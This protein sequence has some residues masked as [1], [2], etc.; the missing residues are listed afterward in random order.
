M[1]KK[2]QKFAIHD[3]FGTKSPCGG[4]YLFMMIIRKFNSL[5]NRREEAHCSHVTIRLICKGRPKLALRIINKKKGKRLISHR[6][7]RIPLLNSLPGG[8]LQE[9]VV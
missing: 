1:H 5:T 6:Y 3:Y 9:L 4:H 8:V 2:N 7:N